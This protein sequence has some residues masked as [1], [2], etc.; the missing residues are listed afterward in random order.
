MHEKLGI[1]LNEISEVRKRA[2]ASLNIGYV[3]EKASDDITESRK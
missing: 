2:L 1:P 3:K